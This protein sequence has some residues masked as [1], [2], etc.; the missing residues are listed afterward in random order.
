MLGSISALCAFLLLFPVMAGC[1]LQSTSVG[2]QADAT[3]TSAPDVAA[4]PTTLP[5]ATAGSPV[6]STTVPTGTIE[7]VPAPAA[8]G[9]ITATATPAGTPTPRPTPSG[10]APE[11]PLL[12]FSP[13]D[14]VLPGDVLVKH[15]FIDL[16]GTAPKEAVVTLTENRLGVSKPLT[17]EVVSAVGI[18]V[19]DSVY[20]EWDPRWL[21][22]PISGT[23]RPLPATNVLG[24]WHGADIL[25]TGQPVVGLRTSTLDGR[26]HL[27]LFRYDKNTR[28]GEP[29][30]MVPQGGGAEQEALFDADLDV[31]VADMDDD[32]VYEVIADNVSG[33]Q[34]WKWD[35]SKY[36]PREAR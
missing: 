8:S 2:A 5:A 24:G 16:D 29:L 12:L 1:S 9:T 28:M 33:V 19:Y 4:T 17:E 18:V 23:A 35:G 34:T 7:A 26:A 20:H 22:V 36:V 3:A 14:Y 32:G 10:P 13:F 27:K 31:T 30:K 6:T 11:D 15:D 21:S 25:R